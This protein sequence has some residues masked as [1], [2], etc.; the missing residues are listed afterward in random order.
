MKILC[1]KKTKRDDGVSHFAVLLRRQEFSLYLEL[2]APG[3]VTYLRHIVN[4][5]ICFLGSDII[6]G[7]PL[8]VT[9]RESRQKA[10]R[11]S[12]LWNEV[13]TSFRQEDL[14]SDK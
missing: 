5:G 13:I 2:V 11:F 7:R 8:Q 6:F 4:V 10:S 1:H 14:I 9:P 3:I 12:Q